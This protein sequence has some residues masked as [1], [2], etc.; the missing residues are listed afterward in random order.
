MP[1]SAAAGLAS[2]RWRLAAL[3]ADSARQ[4]VVRAPRPACSCSQEFCTLLAQGCNGSV[5][6][7]MRCVGFVGYVEKLHSTTVWAGHLGDVCKRR[8]YK[9][10]Y[11]CM[12]T[13][14]TKYQNANRWHRWSTLAHISHQKVDLKTPGPGVKSLPSS[15]PS[16][17]DLAPWKWRPAHSVPSR[18][19]YETKKFT[20]Q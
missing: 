11:E 13:A 10:W 6:P 18:P 5:A 4:R 16:Q 15:A 14:F 20:E 3:S 19:V 1:S 9:N 8:F 7:P 12:N 17:C 2:W